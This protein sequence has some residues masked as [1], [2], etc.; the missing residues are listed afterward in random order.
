M[1]RMQK[2][3]GR[4]GFG[5]CLL[6]VLVPAVRAQD[7]TRVQV[8][9]P[10]RTTSED[11]KA[12]DE[13]RR[14]TQTLPVDP[15]RPSRY[16]AP[17]VLEGVLNED[18]YL[19]G[20]LDYLSVT[21]AAG[22]VKTEL[23]PVLPEGVVVIPNVG[24]VPAA[25]KNLKQFRR[26][27]HDAVAQRYQNFELYC[28]LARAR[29]VRVFVT[30][31]VNAPGAVVAKT[32]ERIV[33]LVER[34][35]GFTRQASHRAVELRAAD[36]SLVQRVDLTP[37]Y[38]EGDLSAN[39]PIGMAQVIFVP[40][41]T[42]QV[43][44]IG[45]VARA[46]VHELRQGDTL[47]RLLELVGGPLPYADLTRITVDVLRPDGSSSSRTYDA[48]REDPLL[49]DVVRVTVLSSLVGR[50]RVVVISPSGQRRIFYLAAGD[51]LRELALR[52]GDFDETAELSKAVLATRHDS[53]V[54]QSVPVDLI[55]VLRGDSN[56]E[57]RD[58]DTL[59]IPG[60]RD[61][62]YVTGFV[63]RPGR[64]TYRSDWRVGHYV[65][66]AGGT[67][68]G[69]NLTDARV[70]REDGTQV[71]LERND[72][73]QRGDTIYVDRSTGGKWVAGL[74]ILSNFSAL[75]ISIVALTR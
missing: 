74:A 46:G 63:Q 45:Q 12:A 41:R 22:E 28:H 2:V 39:P 11:D 29:E 47:S 8:Q 9:F 69:G 10:G 26:D 19:L 31:E 58:G 21:I 75:I 13:A 66:E 35:S 68:R 32:Y 4:L 53:G 7:D 34:A 37:F 43:E 40:T 27:L 52:I 36:G 48:T 30:G 70:F 60:P 71:K 67:A 23:M 16:T 49:D 44:V 50:P 51:S 15:S 18:E 14:Q 42:R 6:V 1:H 25:G 64:Y 5:L 65:G 38:A 62:I 17:D 56:H 59:S 24:V 55:S 3:V 61:F 54:A 20:P 72:P 73:L 33:D 57:I